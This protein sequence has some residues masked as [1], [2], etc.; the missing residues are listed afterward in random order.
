[1]GIAKRS[2]SCSVVRGGRYMYTCVDTL[3][4]ALLV[5]EVTIVSSRVR[6]CDDKESSQ[7][8]EFGF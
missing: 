1:M 5:S 8:I 7:Y 6:S 2:R 3:S 4:T